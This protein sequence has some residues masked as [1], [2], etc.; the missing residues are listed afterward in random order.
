MDNVLFFSYNGPNFVFIMGQI[1][2]FFVCLFMDIPNL[3]SRTSPL[4]HLTIIGQYMSSYRA[5]TY[6]LN[7]GIYINVINITLLLLIHSKQ[8]IADM[9]NQKSA[10][11]FLHYQGLK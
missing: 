8:L 1:L 5:F 10:M 2:F 4:F 11:K 3:L 7:D 9:K 6:L